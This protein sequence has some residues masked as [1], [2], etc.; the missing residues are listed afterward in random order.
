MK[1]KKIVTIILLLGFINANLATLP[2]QAFGFKKKQCCTNNLDII[3]YCWWQNFNDKNLECYIQQALKCNHDIKLANLKIQ[4]YCYLTRIQLGKE[5]PTIGVGG[6]YSGINAD[7]T[8]LGDGGLWAFPLFAY[9]ELDL[10]GKNRNK[11]QA[12]KKE[13]EATRFEA[14]ATYISIIGAVAGTYYNIV[15]LDK[16]IALQQEIINYKEKI[17]DL[18]KKRNE[19]GIAST[20]DTVRANKELVL[21]QTDLINF[22]KSRNQM[23]NMLCVLIGES[24][25]K[26]ACINRISYDELALRNDIPSQISSEVIVHRPDIMQ[27][28]KRIEKA[29][30]D[31][32]V[33]R[34]ELL[35]TFNIIGLLLFSSN[36]LQRVF[37]WDRAVGILGGGLGWTFT[38]GQRLANLGLKKNY[39]EQILQTYHKTNLQAIQ[40]VNDSL[41]NL[42]LDL[43]KYAQGLE[44]LALQQKEFGFVEKRYERGVISYLDMIEQKE[45]LL[46]INKTVVVDK[47]DCFIDYISLYKATGA[48]IDKAMNENTGCGCIPENPQKQKCKKTKKTPQKDAK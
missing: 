17:Y 26:S 30:L 38:G 16:L 22:E 13:W 47:T 12:A 5:L 15:K 31:V 45:A 20:A 2:V 25:D 32:K 29:G 27:A 44:K 10:Y 14:K 19:Q 6:Y 39:Y 9:Y 36:S 7:P 43:E 33:A 23:L 46:T 48:C 35:P 8:T 21:A 11:T 41:S 28:E 34:K 37:N 24:P 42:K 40:E 3:N 1:L 4:E 18:T